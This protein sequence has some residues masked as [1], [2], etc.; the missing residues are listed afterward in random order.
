[1]E[2]HQQNQNFL[3]SS[4]TLDTLNM[5]EL[6]SCA[7]FNMGGKIRRLSMNVACGQG[8][9]ALSVWSGRASFDMTVYACL[10]VC[11]VHI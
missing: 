7:L 3:Y 8:E 9:L 11:V 10:H 4:L 5:I 2:K 6:M 1:V